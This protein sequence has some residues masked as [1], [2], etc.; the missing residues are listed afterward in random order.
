MGVL[1]EG[2]YQNKPNVLLSTGASKIIQVA[3]NLYLSITVINI[4]EN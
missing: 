3:S 2:A 1:R 4:F